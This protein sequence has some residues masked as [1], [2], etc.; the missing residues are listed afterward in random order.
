MN[1]CVRKLREE[2]DAGKVRRVLLVRFGRMGENMFW[3]PV[4]N[5]IRAVHPGLQVLV[6]TNQPAL[7]EGHP[8]V[9]EVLSFPPGMDRK[10]TL[11]EMEPVLRN[12]RGKKLDTI[13]VGKEPPAVMEMLHLVGVPHLV[14]RN[15]RAEAGE[16]PTIP[17]LHNGGGTERY[18]MAELAVGDAWPLGIGDPPWPMVLHVPEEAKRAARE[19]LPPGVEKFAI[20]NIGTHQTTRTW[21]FRRHDRTWPIR[22][23]IDTARALL[24]VEGLHFLL[25][26]HSPRER[27]RAKK[28]VKALPR[29]RAF[30]P[31]EP[32]SLKVLAALLQRCAC[33]ITCDTGIMHMASGLET[34]VV[35][36][37]GPRTSP[38]NTG[39][40]MQGDRAI[41]VRS[42]R[43]PIASITGRQVADAARELLSRG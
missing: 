9:E 40:Y 4:P 3:T 2:L 33:L 23:F 17:S 15:W 6:L 32:P 43:R 8:G 11:K 42:N 35:D 5:A 36:I 19:L 37:N 7:W 31:G 25:S 38:E 21:P 13:V 24:D 28:L 29:G 22:N 34:P 27:W 1:E 18:H 14:D 20:V 16:G 12:L 30:L 39:P 10:G 26:S 41:V